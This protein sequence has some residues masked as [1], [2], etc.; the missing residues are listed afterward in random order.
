MRRSL[1]KWGQQQACPWFSAII[2]NMIDR[3]YDDC[4][5]S[6]QTIDLDAILVNNYYHLPP[7]TNYARDDTKA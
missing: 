1:K 2:G 4:G 5:S 6:W 3:Q 7:K